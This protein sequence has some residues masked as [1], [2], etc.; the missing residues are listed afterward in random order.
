VKGLLDCY[1]SERAADHELDH[2]TFHDVMIAPIPGLSDLID[3]RLDDVAPDNPVAMREFDRAVAGER[4]CLL[5]T[6]NGLYGPASGEPVSALQL[7]WLV[8]WHARRLESARRSGELRRPPPPGDLLAGAA[9]AVSLAALGIIA[10]FGLGA[11]YLLR[12]ATAYARDNAAT[13]GPAVEDR[14]DGRCPIQRVKLRC[15]SGRALREVS[16]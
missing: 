15:G 7:D 16:G 4:H 9:A 6:L 5:T 10:G 8:R 13:G 14:P 2:D 12:F 1:I 11:A 3:G